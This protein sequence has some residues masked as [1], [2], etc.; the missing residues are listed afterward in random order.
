MTLS[1]MYQLPYK[2][3]NKLELLLKL[4]LT[5]NF[6]LNKFAYNISYKKNVI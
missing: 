6:T 3:Y 2:L 5:K 1:S 4:Q